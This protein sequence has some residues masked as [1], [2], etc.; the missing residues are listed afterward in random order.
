[1]EL[2]VVDVVILIALEGPVNPPNP[3][4]VVELVVPKEAEEAAT[5]KPAPSVPDEAT[6]VVYV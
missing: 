2:F 3:A 5:P 6:F 1:M 4:V